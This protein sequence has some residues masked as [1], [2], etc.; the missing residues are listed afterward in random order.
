MAPPPPPPIGPP[1]A[2]LR[3]G[4]RS[5]V[6]RKIDSI[7]RRPGSTLS[8]GQ[9]ARVAR[10]WMGARRPRVPGQ[11]APCSSCLRP[12]KR[13]GPDFDGKM[14]R[15]ARA[16][17]SWPA[18]PTCRICTVGSDPAGFLAPIRQAPKR[19]EEFLDNGRPLPRQTLDHIARVHRAVQRIYSR[20]AMR[21][22]SDSPAASALFVM[23]AAPRSTSNQSPVGGLDTRLF[24]Q[25][26]NA[27]AAGKPPR[28]SPSSAF[29]R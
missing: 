8:S 13:T 17:T 12:G 11:W 14:I 2:G 9:R 24:V 4:S 6:K 19:Y 18:R 23:L 16:T 15:T 27:R 10:S 29:S 25:L 21:Q 26:S 22:S 20:S 1:S 28:L 3:D 7:F 5:F